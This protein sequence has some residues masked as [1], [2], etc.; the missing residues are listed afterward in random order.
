M[1]VL[2]QRKFRTTFISDD[3]FVFG[4][5][6]IVLYNVEHTVLGDI[7]SPDEATTQLL[8]YLSAR[9]LVGNAIDRNT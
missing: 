6:T 5:N 9:F 2:I 7:F 3:C 4:G 1:W 8:F